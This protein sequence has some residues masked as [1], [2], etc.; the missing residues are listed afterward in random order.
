MEALT[1]ML[2]QAWFVLAIL[3][4]CLMIVKASIGIMG[5]LRDIKQT[6]DYY[7]N[8]EEFNRERKELTREASEIL[9]D[10]KGRR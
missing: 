3:F 1:E 4:M 9:N 7:Q 2:L 6:N 10:L 5:E 8:L